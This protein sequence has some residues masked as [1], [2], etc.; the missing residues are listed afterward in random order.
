MVREQHFSRKE[1]LSSFD[2]LAAIALQR[3][4]LPSRAMVLPSG[5]TFV[6]DLATRWFHIQTAADGDTG[7]KAPLQNNGFTTFHT[8]VMS[9][10]I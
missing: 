1:F 4:G 2:L 9:L 6:H 8:F 10:D 7:G 3:C 5:E